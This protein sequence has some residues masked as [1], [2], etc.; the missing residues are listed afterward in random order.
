MLYQ[1]FRRKGWT[2]WLPW[3]WWPEGFTKTMAEEVPWRLTPCWVPR[4]VLRC[5][6]GQGKDVMPGQIKRRYS[7]DTAIISFDVRG[8]WG[9]DPG[10]T[11]PGKECIMKPVIVHIAL[12]DAFVIRNISAAMLTGNPAEDMDLLRAF[13]KLVEFRVCFRML[14]DMIRSHAKN[15]GLMHRL[16]LCII[17]ILIDIL[18]FLQ[19]SWHYLS[20]MFLRHQGQTQILRVGSCFICDV[21]HSFVAA[22]MVRVAGTSKEFQC[23]TVNCQLSIIWLRLNSN[24]ETMDLPDDIM[25]NLESMD[26]DNDVHRQTQPQPTPPQPTPPQPT[27]PQPQHPPPPLP[28]PVPPAQPTLSTDALAQSA[29][30]L[31]S[32]EAPLFLLV[33]HGCRWRHSLANWSRRLPWDFKC[34][35]WTTWIGQ[36]PSHFASSAMKDPASWW[37]WCRGWWGKAAITMARGGTRR[38]LVH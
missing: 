22:I 29:T 5:C 15:V 19:V 27:P 3:R 23:P 9:N 7:D 21:Q 1:R 6:W 18:T 12:A 17:C 2:P 30:C 32:F 31:F 25:E 35:M 37:D 36:G 26:P 24:D 4:L 34:S 20:L 14:A 16:V 8:I 13:L 28:P 10:E 38:G 11:Y 33:L